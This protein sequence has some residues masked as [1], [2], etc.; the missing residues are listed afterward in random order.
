MKWEG[1]RLRD[2]SGIYPLFLL[3]RCGQNSNSGVSGPLRAG[4]SWGESLTVTSTIRLERYKGT[5]KNKSMVFTLDIFQYH[6]PFV[7]SKHK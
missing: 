7:L 6:Y 4:G 2:R 3:A 1:L 5:L